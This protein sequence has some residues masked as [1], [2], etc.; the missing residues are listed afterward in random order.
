MKMREVSGRVPGFKIGRRAGVTPAGPLVQAGPLVIGTI[1]MIVALAPM[2]SGCAGRSPAEAENREVRLTSD[3]VVKYSPRFSPDGAWIAYAAVTGGGNAVAVYVIPGRGGAAKR[4][5]PD[6]VSAFPLTWSSDAQSIYCKSLEAHDIYQ[7]GIDGSVK[8]V[9]AVDPVAR[10]TAISPDGNLRLLRK[11]NQDNSDIGIIEN[12]GAFRFIAHTPAWEDE[13]VIGPG[14]GE[15]TVVSTP[16]YQAPTSTI[17]VWSPKTKTF[18][19][20][21]LPEG[22]KSAPAWSADGRVLAFS[23]RRDGKNDVWLYDTKSARSAQITDEAED[24]GS[25]SWAPDGDWIAICRSTKIS[26]IYVGDPKKEGRRQLTEGADY[27]YAPL[28]SP[29]GHWVAFARRYAAGEQRGKSVLCVAPVAG[30]E[31]HPL[32]LKGVSLPGKGLEE[33]V[34]WSPDSRQIAFQGSEGAA[35]MDVYSIGRDGDGLARVTVEPGD[36][37]EPSW[38]PDGRFITYTRVGGGQTRVA[39]VPASGGLPRFLSPD[40][41]VSEGCLVSPHSDRVVYAAFPQDGTYELWMASFEHP[42]RRTLLVKSK[43]FTWPMFWSH[44]GRE[45]LVMRGQGITWDLIARSADSGTETRVGRHVMLPSGKDMFTE[46]SPEGK[47]YQDLYYPGGIVVADGQDR[48]DLYLIRARMPDKPTALYMR[49]DRFL[50]SGF[51]GLAGCF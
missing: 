33:G 6:S 51:V 50:C 45:I 3:A 8:K 7:I 36:E 4:I 24:S 38:S 2:F 5:T 46:L 25:P 29:D 14:A 41:V 11:F 13:A 30:G 47:K 17:S 1:G 35:R 28:V 20:L 19:A 48:S 21:P 34:A 16:S 27:D 18:S 49:E 9:E 37:I 23:F 15:F 40:G 32:D 39:V 12:G 22:Q 31:V 44:D 26:H 42:E 10:V 43:L